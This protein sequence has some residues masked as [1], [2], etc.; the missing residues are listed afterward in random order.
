MPKIL[1]AAALAAT[2]TLFAAPLARAGDSGHIPAHPSL[3]Q[4]I[5]GSWRTPAYVK[6]DKYRHPLE[7]LEFFG[8]QPDMSVVEIDPGGGWWTEFL[9]PYLKADG[10]LTETV[11]PKDATGFMGK[12]RKNFLAKLKASPELYSKVK[13]VPF[14]PPKTVKLGPANSADMVITFRN[15]HDWLNADDGAAKAVFKAAYEVLKP[16]GVFGISDHRALPF[17]KGR[18]S[19]K[20]LHR[21]P[22]DFVIEM[23]LDT[24][25]R[26]AGVSQVNRN[27]KDPMTINIHHLPPDLSHDTAAQKKKYLKIGE[28]DVFVMKFVKPEAG[29]RASGSGED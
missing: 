18:D 13:T 22:E 20:K 27:P 16:G 24:G 9:A 2:L 26:L 8:M 7:V 12:M 14:A 5:N 23:G 28:S 3:K 25:F 19:A 11:P 17:A 21:I 4:A 29:K 15:M 1:A 10:Q 6:R